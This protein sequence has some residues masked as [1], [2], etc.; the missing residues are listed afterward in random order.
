MAFHYGRINWEIIEEYVYERKNDISTRDVAD[1]FCVDIRTIYSHFKSIGKLD[2]FKKGRPST[3]NKTINWEDIDSFIMDNIGKVTINQVS[4]KFKLQ[5]C[6]V[7]DHYR[8]K[9]K[10]Y[11]FE[12]DKNNGRRTITNWEVIDKIVIPNIDRLSI[13]HVSDYFGLKYS[14]VYNHYQSKNLIEEF[15]TYNPLNDLIK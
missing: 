13:K 12:K 4:E 14:V 10:L 2:L 7:H 3:Y 5:Y 11:L 9:N 6:T 8:R 15:N 1:K